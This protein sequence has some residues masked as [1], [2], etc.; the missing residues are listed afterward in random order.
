M[1]KDST[2]YVSAESLIYELRVARSLLRDLNSGLE[3]T[4]QSMAVERLVTTMIGVIE[5]ASTL[6]QVPLSD[7][8]SPAEA[9][10]VS[11]DFEPS[12]PVC[13]GWHARSSGEG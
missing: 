6:F 8:G 7:E 13:G 9:G 10:V 1:R 3:Q 11:D 2:L 5:D 12:C 4:Q